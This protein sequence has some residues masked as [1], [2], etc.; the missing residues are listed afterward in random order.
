MKLE[1]EGKSL[2]IHIILNMRKKGNFVLLK[3]EEFATDIRL[4]PMI[5]RPHQKQRGLSRQL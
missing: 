3:N 2:N 4:K 5:R 1:N